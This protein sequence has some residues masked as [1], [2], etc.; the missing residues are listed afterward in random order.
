MKIGKLNLSLS[1]ILAVGLMTMSVSTYAAK[2]KAPKKKGIVLAEGDRAVYTQGSGSTL[3]SIVFPETLTDEEING[4]YATDI[5]GYMT[6]IGHKMSPSG[7][8]VNG[9][10]IYYYVHNSKEWLFK[11]DWANPETTP[12]KAIK[13]IRWGNFSQYL[14]EFV[15][16]MPLKT[17]NKETKS[18]QSFQDELQF[19]SNKYYF[20]E[21][22]IRDDYRK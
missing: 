10:S 19:G 6:A 11:G 3:S 14:R 9:I 7:T 1:L 5:P 2:E 17:E 12:I 20:F 4:L 21:I 22:V 16:H 18:N 13:E 15:Q 8:D